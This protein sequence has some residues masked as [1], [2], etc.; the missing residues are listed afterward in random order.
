[1]LLK[2]IRFVASSRA[3][4]FQDRADL[5]CQQ[6]LGFPMHTRL[7]GRKKSLFVHKEAGKHRLPTT[8]IIRDRAGAE[9]E[10]PRMGEVMPT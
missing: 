4:V 6:R 9:L 5:R 1:M 2:W 3:H 8:D 10:D 7:M